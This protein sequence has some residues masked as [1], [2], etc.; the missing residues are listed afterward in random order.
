MCR[1]PMKFVTVAPD[2]VAG[3][4]RNSAAIRQLSQPGPQPL[5]VLQLRVV[6]VG[7]LRRLHRY[8]QIAFHLGQPMVPDLL[9]GQPVDLGLEG[10]SYARS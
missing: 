6:A 3:W 7:Q 9:P 2:R 1:I 10:T 5:R 4:R 8:S